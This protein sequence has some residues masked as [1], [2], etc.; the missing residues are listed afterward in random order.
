MDDFK[1]F[2]APDVWPNNITLLDSNITAKKME[3]QSSSTEGNYL[4]FQ[5]VKTPF[6]VA[7][8]CLFQSVYNI[9]LPNGDF[10]FVQTSRG[11]DQ[12]KQANAA[13]VGKKVVSMNHFCYTKFEALQDGS[14]QIIAVV[15]VDA[16]G[17]LPQWMK[18]KIA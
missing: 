8:R 18:K 3:D 5:H 15:C 12:I 13:M 11:N 9:D 6:I 7:D 16:A 1:A 4:M 14:I 10:I 2:H 17:D